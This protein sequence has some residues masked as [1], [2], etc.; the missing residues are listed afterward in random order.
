ML[1][2]FH[3]WWCKARKRLPFWFWYELQGSTAAMQIITAPARSHLA[4]E[5]LP[6]CTTQMVGG[7]A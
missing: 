4:I 2:P 1:L 7:H 3:F 6:Y 5:H